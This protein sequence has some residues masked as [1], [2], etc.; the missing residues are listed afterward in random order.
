ME[1]LD[2]DTLKGKYHFRFTNLYTEWHSHPV[3]E[4]IYAQQGSFSLSY[5]DK[6]VR[7]LVFAV[8]KANVPHKLCLENAAVEVLMIESYN[9]RFQGFFAREAWDFNQGVFCQKTFG[10]AGAFFQKLKEFAEKD[11][12]RLPSDTRVASSLEIL[13]QEEI[14]FKSLMASL[15]EKT[16]LSESRLSHLFKEHI[17]VSIKK[18]Q[19]WVKLRTAIHKYLAEGGNLTN[20]ALEGRFFDQAHLTN[21]FKT[22]LGLSPSKVYNSRT[23]QA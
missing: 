6:E 12:H 16:R 4:I 10:S 18:Y 3:V 7:D 22:Y 15:C 1:V 19:V 23:L 9:E 14:E 11:N 8:I 17:G 20:A 13:E 21:A 2:F 5:E